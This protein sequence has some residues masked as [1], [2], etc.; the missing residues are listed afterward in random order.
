M[1]GPYFGIHHVSFHEDEKVTTCELKVDFDD[2]KTILSK[3]FIGSAMRNREDKNHREIGRKL[4][5]SRALAKVSRKLDKLA[6]GDIRNQENI[7]LEK[8]KRAQNLDEILRPKSRREK[9]G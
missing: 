8:Q 6:W 3:S 4:A 1:F 9:V 7:K 2:G 5:L